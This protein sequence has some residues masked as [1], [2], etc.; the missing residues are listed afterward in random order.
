M[1]REAFVRRLQD[2]YSYL[3]QCHLEGVR[4]EG[5]VGARPNGKN[6]PNSHCFVQTLTLRSQ[7]RFNRRRERWKSTAGWHTTPS[8]LRRHSTSK[9][10]ASS[11]TCRDSTL[12]P[13]TLRTRRWASSSAAC[14][15]AWIAVNSLRSMAPPTGRFTRVK[16][17]FC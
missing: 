3:Q 15:A 16:R 8:T 5:E 9:S 17:G 10:G 14:P 11:P 13:P 7:L 12:W 1:D 2:Y 4:M 6:G